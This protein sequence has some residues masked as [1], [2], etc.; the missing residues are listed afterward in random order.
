MKGFMLLVVALAATVVMVSEASAQRCNVQQSQAVST[1]SAVQAAALAQPLLTQPVAQPSF[2]QFQPRSATA[3]S[4]R[5]A[6]FLNQP[7]QT[8]VCTDCQRQPV[9]AAPRQAV[10]TGGSLASALPR[11]LAPPQTVVVKKQ[12]SGP[13]R[14]LLD[15]GPVSK[16]ISGP[17][18]SIAVVR[19]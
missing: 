9:V 11:D 16:S 15:P 3:T 8:Q 5:V 2:V 7:D 6:Q 13:L 4:G 17:R 12:R 19:G 18:R 1:A 10:A 14:N